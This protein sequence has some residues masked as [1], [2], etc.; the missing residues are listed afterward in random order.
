LRQERSTR[1]RDAEAS[2]ARLLIS[3]LTNNRGD[4]P[5][6]YVATLARREI[7]AAPGPTVAPELLK[8]ISLY[9]EKTGHAAAFA[10]TETERKRWWPF[11]RRKQ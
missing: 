10:G 7:E 9:S 2:R 11:R 5:G 4:F 6:V 1:N 8:A 3:F